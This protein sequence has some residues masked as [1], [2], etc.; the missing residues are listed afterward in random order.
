MLRGIVI[1]LLKFIQSISENMLK[2]NKEKYLDSTFIKEP[3]LYTYVTYCVSWGCFGY[4]KNDETV[5]SM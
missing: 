4:S 1:K 5:R 3:V 2:H